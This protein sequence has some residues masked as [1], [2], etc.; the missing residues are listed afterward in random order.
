MNTSLR[1]SLALLALGACAPDD[2][3]SAQTPTPPPAAVSAS[4]DASRRTAIVDAT[5][6]VAPAVVSV[7]AVVR[8][9]VQPS[10]MDAFF[11]GGP[12]EQ[13][14]QSFGTGFVIRGDG[15]IVTNQ[16]VVAGSE[17][18]TITLADG[19]DVDGRVLGEDPLTDI[20]VIKV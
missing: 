5:A 12:R 7:R 6:R 4:I 16:H 20:A 8:Q 3:A 10:A 9:R 11:F 13:Q 2:G 1:N 14:S 19:T 17:Q 15:I 18:I